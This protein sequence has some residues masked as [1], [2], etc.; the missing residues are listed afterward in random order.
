VLLAP[1]LGP[2]VAGWLMG[3]ATACAI[4]GRSVVARVLSPGT[5]RRTVAAVA[6]AVQLIGTLLLCAVDSSQ[7]TL[8]VLAIVLFGSGI[9]NAT[10]LPPLIAQQEFARA[11]VARV[12]ALIVAIAQGT[13]AFAPAVFGALLQ[14]SAGAA[15]RIGQGTGVF[16]LA[17]AAVQVLALV[18]FLCGRRRA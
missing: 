7:V 12:V 10:S 1:L 11:D 18:C 6:Y 13:Y 16:L 8:I 2:Q 15:A 17:V 9:G 3:G 5:Q 14:A 4:V